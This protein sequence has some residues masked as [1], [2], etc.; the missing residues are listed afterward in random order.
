MSSSN[1]IN[2]I[3]SHETIYSSKNPAIDSNFTEAMKEELSDALY[4]N[5]EKYSDILHKKYFQDQ[6]L[7]SFLVG[8]GTMLVVSGIK[9]SKFILGNDN[10]TLV[11]LLIER[12]IVNKFIRECDDYVYFQS[13]LNDIQEN[14]LPEDEYDLVLNVKTEIKKELRDE[15]KLL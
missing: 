2:I 6:P 10:L 1:Y 8:F 15:Y 5:S 7:Y 11:Y 4:K 3:K 14:N 9:D 12:I 13:L